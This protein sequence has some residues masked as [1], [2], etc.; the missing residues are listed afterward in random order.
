MKNE[1][2]SQALNEIDD[3][4]IQQ[5]A[6]HQ[7]RRRSLW[8]AVAA[9]S[10]ALCILLGFVFTIPGGNSDPTKPNMEFTG[11]T[12]P[13]T[14]STVTTIPSM[15]TE[16]TIETDPTEP[17]AT[18]G[19]PTTEYT[20]TLYVPNEKWDGFIESEITLT[21]LDPHQILQ[22]LQDAG[23]VGEDV[24]ILSATVDGNSMLTLDMN[25]AFLMDIYAMGATGE[26]MLMGSLVNTFLSAFRYA[27][28]K[29]MMVT[30]E[31]E[32]IRSGH[33]DYD[34]PFYPNTDAEN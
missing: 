29:C 17:E 14:E 24:A 12:A 30:A 6:F 7:R 33:V 32:I 10:L 23:V 28:C 22:C 16:P 2:I 27:H 31:G 8:Y 21:A 4:Y 1:K 34:F 19:T 13:S 3:R 9:A 15:G 5:A 26:S 18:T 25:E 20:F 11:S